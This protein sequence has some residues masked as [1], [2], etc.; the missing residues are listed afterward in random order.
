MDVSGCG[1]IESV[2][3][4]ACIYEAYARAAPLDAKYGGNALLTRWAL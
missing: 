2:A 3:A 4:A 1:L